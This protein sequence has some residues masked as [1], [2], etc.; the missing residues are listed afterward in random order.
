MLATMPASGCIE[1]IAIGHR[2]GRAISKVSRV[3]LIQVNIFFN[4]ILSVR[5]RYGSIL[6]MAL[7]DNCVSE[8]DLTYTQSWNS[9]LLSNSLDHLYEIHFDLRIT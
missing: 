5:M 6:S 4:E 8:S 3:N 7:N 9:Y 2:I 1:A